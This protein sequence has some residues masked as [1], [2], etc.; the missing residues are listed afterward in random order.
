MSTLSTRQTIGLV[1]IFALTSICFIALDNRNALDP[2]KTALH[3][4]VVPV[5]DEFNRIGNGGN[6]DLAKQLEQVKRERDAALAENAQLKAEQKD[7]DQLKQIVG[8]EQS[9]PERKLVTARVLGVDPMNLQKFVT[10]DKGALDGIKE[11]MAVVDPNY[12]VGLVIGPVGEHS[13][14]VLLAIDSSAAVG[15]QLLDSGADGIVYGR[16]QNQGRMEMGYVDRSIK[17]KA[18]ETVVT[19]TNPETRTAGVPGNLIIGKVE[20]APETFNQSDTQT[21]KVLPACDFDHLTLV[22]VIVDDGESGS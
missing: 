18:G 6:S 10:I 16:W 1:V 13:A 19:S 17:A 15:A 14:K 3:D 22:A 11:G 12:F 21:I 7:I 8:Y 9:H 4:L 5:T 20:D 2:L